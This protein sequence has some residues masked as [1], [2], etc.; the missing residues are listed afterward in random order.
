MKT[1]LPTLHQ[2]I[3]FEAVARTLS[4]TAAA[5][6]LCVT[7][8]A[9]SRQI[10]DLE[11]NLGTLLFHRTTRRLAITSDGERYVTAVR[12]SLA[13]LADATRMMKSESPENEVRIAVVSAFAVHWIYPRFE[14]FKRQH[15]ES[16]IQLLRYLG[17]ASALEN[18]KQAHGAIHLGR[19]N[20]EKQISEYLGGKQLYCGL[21]PRL[22]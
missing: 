15:P 10:R 5:Q 11:E 14:S 2:L 16:K 8:G 19:G 3:A 7:Q 17:E 18:C 20:W 13:N 21:Q 22:P 4:F 12:P 6:E 1:I 9:I